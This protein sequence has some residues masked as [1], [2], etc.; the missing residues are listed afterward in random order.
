MFRITGM[1][2]DGTGIP[3]VAGNVGEIHHQG[4][5]RELPRDDCKFLSMNRTTSH[6]LGTP[7]A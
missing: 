1:T 4:E 7:T 2:F 3:N 6:P 5:L